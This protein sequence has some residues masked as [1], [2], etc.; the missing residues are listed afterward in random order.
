[1]ASIVDLLVNFLR[2][3]RNGYRRLFGRA[4]DY[5]VFEV[6]GGLPEFDPRVGFLRRRINPGP[7]VLSLE[8]VRRRLS[9][10]TDDG[11]VRGVVLRLQNLDA[12]WAAL[13]ELRRGLSLYRQGGGRVVV[14]LVEA[15]TRSYYLACAADEILATPLAMVGVT[16]LRT[17]INFL[18]E[19]LRKVGVEAEVFAV[20][21][22]KSAYDTFARQDF[23]DE[24]REQAER[25]VGRRFAE[26]VD[27]VAE[28]RSMTPEKAREKID[29]APYSA[30]GAVDAGLLDGVCY[31]D[32]LSERLGVDGEQAKLAEWTVADKALKI[33]YR[34][35]SRRRVGVVSLSGAIVW[36]RSRKLPVPL[37]LIGGEQAGSESVVAAL[38]VAEKNRRVASVLFHVDS[39]GGDSLASDLIWREVQRI[40]EKKPVVVLMG[41]AAASGGY[42]VSASADHIVARRN[43]ITGSIGVISL[44]PVAT[45]LYERLYINPVAIGRGKRSGLYDLSRQPTDDER[46]VLAGQVDAIYGEFKDR[47]VKGRNFEPED[48]EKLAGGRV[49]TGVEAHENGLIDELGGWKTALDKARELAGIEIDAPEVVLKISPPKTGRPMPETAA[50]AARALVEGYREALAEYRS[51]RVWAHAPYTLSED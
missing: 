5:V 45:D 40:S 48:L 26:L 23:S 7:P 42:Y 28:G 34:R 43:T 16:G 38:R 14:Y 19:A 1:M 49:W 2:W 29:R 47:V 9:R 6:G 3:L 11:R 51:G 41:D 31:E 35:R 15:D 50:E 21:P 27:A 18:K 37:P 4:P 12:G 13:E 30:S 8:E 20:S 24:A 25:L 10:I 33:P 17:R 22:Y 44:R 39:R 32:E 36:G 46:Q